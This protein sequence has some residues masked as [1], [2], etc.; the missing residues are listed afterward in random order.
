M[1]DQRTGRDFRQ[2]HQPVHTGA[3]SLTVSLAPSRF[4]YA[5]YKLPDSAFKQ[6]ASSSLQSPSSTNSHAFQV[7][8]CN[9]ATLLP[10]PFLWLLPPEVDKDDGDD[11]DGGESSKQQRGLESGGV[12]NVESQPLLEMQ[13]QQKKAY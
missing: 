7:L 6:S 9:V 12:V 2:F 13:E 4:C 1:A 5:V 11:G 3:L 8:L 10:A